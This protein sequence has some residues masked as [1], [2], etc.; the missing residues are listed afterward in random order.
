MKSGEK[1]SGNAE[2]QQQQV[3]SFIQTID[4]VRFFLSNMNVFH[5]KLEFLNKNWQI[6]YRIILLESP[7]FPMISIWNVVWHDARFRKVHY[8]DDGDAS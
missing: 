5:G 7:Q 2:S 3:E 1:M 4:I 6:L 8:V